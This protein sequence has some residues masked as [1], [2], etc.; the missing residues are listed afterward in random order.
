MIIKSLLNRKCLQAPVRLVVIAATIGGDELVRLST[1]IR[2][3]DGRGRYLIGP[4][5]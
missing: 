4:H 5:S 3:R 1:K 2:A